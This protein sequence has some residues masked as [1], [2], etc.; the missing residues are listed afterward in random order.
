MDCSDNMNL[1]PLMQAVENEN[2][3]LVK[4]ILSDCK[5]VNFKG[6]A[7]QTALHIAVDISID[8]TIQSGISKDDA[9]IDI[10]R[11]LLQQG[12]NIHSKDDYNKSPLDWALEYEADKITK[13]LLELKL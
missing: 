8:G 13:L 10:I 7:G 5:D 2:I 3:E 1:T 11:I 12:A 6:H 4:S 9:P